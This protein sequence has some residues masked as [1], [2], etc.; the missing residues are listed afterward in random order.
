M[1]DGADFPTYIESERQRLRDRRQTLEAYMA[2]H[3][4]Q[5]AEIDR[6]FA[7]IDAYEKAKT[8]KSTNTAVTKSVRGGG[9]REAVYNVIGKRGGASR[10]DILEALGVKGDKS[11]EMAVSNALTAMKK[12]GQVV[13]DGG[14]WYLATQSA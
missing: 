11:G 4:S 10:G 5:L 3:Q 14:L 13:K 9:R 6:E 2:E 12:A 1:Y 8:G 7:A